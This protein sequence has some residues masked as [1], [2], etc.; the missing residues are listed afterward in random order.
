MV[1]AIGKEDRALQIY[2]E[3]TMKS[4]SGVDAIIVCFKTAKALRTFAEENKLKQSAK[5]DWIL[6]TS[7]CMVASYGRRYTYNVV[8]GGNRWANEGSLPV[9]M[10]VVAAWIGDHE[11][12]RLLM[13]VHDDIYSPNCS[14]YF[15]SPLGAA[16]RNSHAELFGLFCDRLPLRYEDVEKAWHATARY[17]SSAI[18][19]RLKKLWR[20]S[21]HL[22]PR[23][24]PET[25]L[26]QA[27]A[28][29]QID[30]FKLLLRMSSSP[31]SDNSYLDPSM[32]QVARY[33]HDDIAKYLLEEHLVNPDAPYVDERWDDTCD[34]GDRLLDEYGRL[35]IDEGVSVELEPFGQTVPNFIRIAARH[36]HDNIVKRL[37]EAGSKWQ[38][39]PSD[40]R[41]PVNLATKY[42]H[43]AVIRVLL[44]KGLSSLATGSK[45]M[46]DRYPP[47]ALEDPLIDAA[48]RGYV[49]IVNLLLENKYLEKG[50][51]DSP[52]VDYCRSVIVD[53]AAANAESTMV[54]Y[55]LEK[56]FPITVGSIPY[57]QQPTMLI[58]LIAA[59][60]ANLEGRI[61]PDWK[62]ARILAKFGAP[63]LNPRDYENVCNGEHVGPCPKLSSIRLPKDLEPR[64]PLTP[65]E[66]V[67]N[68][69]HSS[70]SCSLLGRRLIGYSY[71]D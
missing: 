20:D 23:F 18:W 69:C 32:V 15:G 60:Y 38:K 12:V 71:A 11:M 6:A 35:R 45:G 42:G 9:N 50:G 36:G 39:A 13:H 70:I 5:L 44:E 40:E 25:L 54:K 31:I 28:G 43:L 33:G 41:C 55:L 68:I 7:E 27:A 17:G 66:R 53:R 3:K 61:R 21:S 34:I 1:K 67:Q 47:G 2:R 57:K 48:Q 14:E 65:S 56:G 4:E 19:D 46:E 49:D 58:A 37:I 24:M 29:N 62:T 10:L 59:D 30:M 8:Y 22:R 64:M 52:F 26:P 16:A 51:D 63:R